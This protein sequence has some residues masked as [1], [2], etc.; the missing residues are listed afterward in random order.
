MNNF[1]SF[2]RTSVTENNGIYN[3]RILNQIRFR[4]Y[5]TPTFDRVWIES[6][7]YKMKIEG[8]S[9][10]RCKIEETKR[11]T[12]FH[13]RIDNKYSTIIVDARNPQG[14]VVGPVLYSIYSKDP[15][16]MMILYADDTAQHLNQDVIFR[17]LQDILK[18]KFNENEVQRQKKLNI[19]KKFLKQSTLGKTL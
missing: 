5:R 16:N 9:L 4:N 12:Q 17:R 10:K 13:V 18:S 15:R 19:F 8:F 3:G 7:E 14:S 2:H 1:I 6:L 11:E